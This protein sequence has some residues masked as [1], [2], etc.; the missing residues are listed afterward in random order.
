MSGKCVKEE[1]LVF[2]VDIAKIGD[3]SAVTLAAKWDTLR[4]LALSMLAG[5]RAIETNRRCAG[6]TYVRDPFGEY[7]APAEQS[8]YEAA[9]LLRE[10][11]ERLLKDLGEG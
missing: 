10:Q 1:R 8:Y 2:G 6:A 4:A 7:G 3:L 5:A 9:R 11:G